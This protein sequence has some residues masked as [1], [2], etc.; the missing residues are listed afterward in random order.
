MHCTF[1]IAR[2]PSPLNDWGHKTTLP[3]GWGVFCSVLYC[4]FPILLL[5]L[6][7]TLNILCCKAISVKKQ[8][9]L[10][11]WASDKFGVVELVFCNCWTSDITDSKRSQL[12]S[13]IRQAVSHSMFGRTGKQNLI[14][15]MG[16]CLLVLKQADLHAKVSRMFPAI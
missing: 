3:E 11:E 6:A 9:P 5:D 2:F 7:I 4:L 14:A 8:N 13:F 1:R 16:T 10:S 12:Q 15:C